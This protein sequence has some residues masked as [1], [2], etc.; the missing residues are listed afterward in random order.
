MFVS[1][2]I[3]AAKYKEI[4]NWQENNVYEETSDLG[5][6]CISMRWVITEKLKDGKTVVQ[7]RLVAKGFEEE[8]SG[9]RKDFPT[10]AKES[11]ATSSNWNCCIKTVACQFS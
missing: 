10:I 2:D 5:Q 1:D 8:S 7:A 4:Q 3:E 6:S 9:L 11:V